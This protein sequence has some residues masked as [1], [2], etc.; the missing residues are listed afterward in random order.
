MTEIMHASILGP[1]LIRDLLEVQIDPLRLQMVTNFVGEDQRF[2][3]LRFVP[4]GLPRIA[5]SMWN[6]KET[7]QPKVPT[8]KVQSAKMT[9]WIALWKSWLC[10]KL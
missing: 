8:R 7:L 10:C 6:T 3:V 5:I 9:L 1:N 2:A 4:P